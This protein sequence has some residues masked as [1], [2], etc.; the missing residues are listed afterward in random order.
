MVNNTKIRS[1]GLDLWPMTLKFNS[2]LEVVEVHVW[3]KFHQA[4][5]SGS[6]VILLTDKQWNRRK[7]T[8]LKTILSLKQTATSYQLPIIVDIRRS[9]LQGSHT[10]NQPTRQLARALVTHPTILAPPFPLLLPGIL[11][12]HILPLSSRRRLE[13][14]SSPEWTAGTLV[15]K[16]QSV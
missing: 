7:T 15:S 16:H 14:T 5:C 12:P 2:I 11:S 1:C 3:I 13:V 9:V 6:W 4:K 10:A 8:M